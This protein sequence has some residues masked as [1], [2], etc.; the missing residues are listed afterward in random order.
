MLRVA[1]LISMLIATSASAQ[2]SGEVVCTYA[3]SQSK[4]VAAVSGAAGG[5]TATAGAVATATGLTA[6]AHSS[7]AMILTGTSGYIAGTIGGTAATIAA[8]PVVVGVGF[9]VGGVAVTLEL[10]CAAKNHPEQVKKVNDAAAEFS[11]RFANAVDQARTA[12]SGVKKSVVPA[13]RNAVVT[14]KQGAA[15]VWKY[16]YRKSVEISPSFSK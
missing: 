9:L 7:G 15:E 5:A 13:T 11:I 4:I 6:V 14:I 3:P 1:Y 16:A 8:A 2:P 12:G 10:V